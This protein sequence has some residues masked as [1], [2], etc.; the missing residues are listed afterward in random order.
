MGHGAFQGSN[1]GLVCVAL[2]FWDSKKWLHGFGS[3]AAG[4]L[5]V[6]R[7]HVVV[8]SYIWLI[9]A[10]LRHSQARDI[11]RKD[12]MAEY[13]APSQHMRDGHMPTDPTSS[14]SAAQS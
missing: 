5:R 13:H 9:M 6:Y 2:G 11:V 4:C 12:S 10:D 8:K 7:G 14:K 3:G 1:L